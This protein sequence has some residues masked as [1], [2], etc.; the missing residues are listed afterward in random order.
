MANQFG[1]VFVHGADDV[2]FD[3]VYGNET[4]HV[5][6]THEALINELGSDGS[7]SQNENAIIANK[8]RICELALSK[9]S[10]AEGGHVEITQADLVK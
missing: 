10:A 1:W 6:V 9:A 7:Y 4:V 3:V 8:D 5:H 2:L